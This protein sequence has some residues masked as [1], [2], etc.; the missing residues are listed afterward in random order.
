MKK[1]P[2]VVTIGVLVSFVGLASI[3]SVF[4]QESKL[5]VRVTP[6]EPYLFLNERAEPDGSRTLQLSPSKHKIGRYI[7]GY[8]PESR[9]VTVKSGWTAP[10]EV[11]LKSASGDVSGPGY[12]MAKEAGRGSGCGTGASSLCLSSLLPN[13]V[14]GG[15][16]FGGRGDEFNRIVLKEE[17]LVPRGMHQF[18]LREGNK[19]VGSGPVTFATNR[20]AIGS[21]NQVSGKRRWIGRAVK[22]FIRVLGSTPPGPA[23]WRIQAD[24]HR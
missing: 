6:K 8:Q 14:L 23:P 13:A 4:A 3:A 1:R 22:G 19:E 17:L 16:S 21:V 7:H 15:L 11:S 9:S 5:K 2:F 20:R 18:L 12:R 24:W 10:L